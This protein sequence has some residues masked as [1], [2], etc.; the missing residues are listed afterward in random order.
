MAQLNEAK[1]TLAGILL[2]AGR[3]ER[4]GRP[5]ALLPIGGRTFVSSLVDT[6]LAAHLPRVIVVLGHHAEA[7]RRVLPADARVMTAIN[8][9]PEAGQLSSLQAGLR[10]A[11]DVEA[12]V[13]ALVDVPG[14]TAT[15]VELLVERW[16]DTGAAAV[17]PERLGRHGHPV[18]FARDILRVLRDADPAAGA[19]PVLARFSDRVLDV[20][21]EDEGPFT[22]IDTRQDYERS[23]GPWPA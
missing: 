17:R 10:A 15:L 5:K 1:G 11:G 4:M 8:T 21:V 7:I 14:V 19:K 23:V 6:L 12:A 2:A 13:V 18:L 16:R 20:A 22:D 9:A 3:S